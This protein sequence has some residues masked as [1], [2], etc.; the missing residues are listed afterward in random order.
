MTL[1]TRSPPWTRNQRLLVWGIIVAA[2]VGFIPVIDRIDKSLSGEEA[3]P[4]IIFQIFGGS[5]QTNDTLSDNDSSLS[6]ASST[7]SK[8]S[9]SA[10]ARTERIETRR[11]ASDDSVV[12]PIQ[13]QSG[14]STVPSA[15]VGGADPRIDSIIEVGTK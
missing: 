15:K 10:N 7:N 14:V 12:E 5:L 6:K 1:P 9:N 11:T 2:M 4:K 13:E 3:P 8:Q